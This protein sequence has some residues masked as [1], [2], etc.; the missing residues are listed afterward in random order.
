MAE[1]NSPDR[2]PPQ[3]RGKNVRARDLPGDSRLQIRNGYAWVDQSGWW[4]AGFIFLV[5]A[6]YLFSLTKPGKI[7]AIA[8][9]SSAITALP[10]IFF[11]LLLCFG[12]LVGLLLAPKVMISIPPE[13]RRPLI[14][15]FRTTRT[16]A[17]TSSETLSRVFGAWLLLPIVLASFLLVIFLLTNLK[18]G[19]GRLSFQCFLFFLIP[20]N[21]LIAI[22]WTINQ[23]FDNANLRS[24]NLCFLWFALITAAFQL[25]II[26]DTVDY[27]IRLSKSSEHLLMVVAA[28]LMAGI[29]FLCVIQILFVMVIALALRIDS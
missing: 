26:S 11:L 28:W 15:V 24:I 18:E 7:P 16:V 27:S 23:A 13:R 17:T 9:S 14:R 25:F 12:L 22:V 21:A 4:L 8:S 20:V 2:P 5:P 1:P 19:H 6:I 10:I 29:L 3:S